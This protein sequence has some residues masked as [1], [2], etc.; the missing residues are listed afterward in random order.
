MVRIH[1]QFTHK[2]LLSAF[3]AVTAAVLTGCAEVYSDAIRTS[4]FNANIDVEVGDTTTVVSVDLATGSAVDSD[5]IVLTYGDRLRAN[6][7]GSRQAMVRQN[8][9]Y[10]A[11][12]NDATPGQT[13]VVSLERQNDLSALNSRVTLPDRIEITAP[14]AGERYY[15][16]EAI[17]LAWS[18]NIPDKQV[19]IS[20]K[21]KC[22][23]SNGS[24][25]PVYVSSIRTPDT[26]IYSIPVS[27]IVNHHGSEWPLAPGVP[28]SIG[29]SL[30][31]VNYGVL[32]AAFGR[33]GSITASREKRIN[34]TVIP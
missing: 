9:R 26:G 30:E 25:R 32:D 17:T 19:K 34:V 22:T 5:S 13:V 4:G 28:C 8:V 18:P 7:G 15:A 6:L 23:N 16:G 31:R 1:Q 29:V 10:L 11:N 14:G 24:L 20:F 2:I 12:F 3:V 21:G 27:L 33:G